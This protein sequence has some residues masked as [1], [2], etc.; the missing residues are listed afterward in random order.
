M[1]DFERCSGLPAGGEA[2]FNFF[3][4]SGLF[5]N[6]AAGG[7]GMTAVVGKSEGNARFRG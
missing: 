7:D 1:L 2:F 3:E 6:R 4:D 5:L